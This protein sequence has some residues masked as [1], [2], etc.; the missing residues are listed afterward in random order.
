VSGYTGIYVVY[1][2]FSKYLEANITDASVSDTKMLQDFAEKCTRSGEL[3]MHI[4]LISHKEISNYI[5]K[6]PQQ[7]V[8]G[9]R[10][11]SER[12]KHIHLNNNF[13]QTYEIISTVIQKD[14]ALWDQF[15]DVHQKDFDNLY[16]R[17]E[18]H[19]I[20]LDATSEL[21][22]AI[23]GCFPLQPIS[24]FILPRLSER[25]AQNERTLFTFLSARGT[26]TLPEFLDGYNDEAFS[27]ITPDLLYDYFE[28]LFK[29]EAYAGDI[30]AKYILTNIILN[31]LDP[32]SLGSK[33]VKTI[34]L[35][36]I[37]EQFEKLKPTKEEIVGIYSASY[38]V[39]TIEAAI[40][41]LIKKEFV[42]YVKRSNDYLRLK[43]TSG[44]DVQQKIKDFVELY[45]DR[46][47]IKDTLNN[48][49]F[50]NYMY[51][52]RYNDD[53][54]MIRYFS[55]EFIEGLEITPEIDW[56]K[57]SEGS[58]SDGI[59]FGIIPSGDEGLSDLKKLVV[60]TSKNCPRYI[61]VLP[62]CYKEI[63]SVIR[64]YEAVKN[65]REKAINDPVLFD[66]YEVVFEDLQEIIKSFISKYT[67]P[68]T[69]ASFYIYD[70]KELEIRRKAAL[71]EL[72]SEICD[73]IYSLTPVINNESVNRREITS[74]AANSR[75]K[76]ISGLL[77]GELESN[78]G[79]TGSGQEVS[80]MRSTLIR[81]G[82]WKEE[83]GIP[84]I[85]L[86]PDNANMGNLLS[87]IE[88]FILEARQFGT[89]SFRV[90]YDRL[91][92]PDN[93]IGLRNGLIPIYIAVVMHEYRQ[94]I[95]VAGKSGQV[96]LNT[97]VLMQ[98]NA[99]P[100]DFSLEYL[101]WNP[102][103]ETYTKELSRVFED[104]VVNAEKAG[105]SYDYVAN[106]MRRWY[107]ALPK[108]SK[109]C[110]KLP[111]GGLI[112]KRKQE[113]IKLLRQNISGSELLF[114]KI[115]EIFGYDEFTVDVTEEVIN[116]KTL[117]DGLLYE[118]RE[119]LISV[120][121]DIFTTSSASKTA[122]R[123][124]LVSI[125]REWLE[126]LDESVGEQLFADGT[127]KF[128]ELISSVTNDE[129][130]FISRVA[131]LA[132]DLRLEDWD[133]KMPQLYIEAIK[134][135][136]A[137]AEAFRGQKAMET[138]DLT[139]GYQVTFV[140]EEGENVTK[141]FD[142]VDVSSRGKLLHN[143]ITAALDSMGHSITEQEKRQ[144]LMEV[145]RKLC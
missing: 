17:Y 74:V 64:E 81:T 66:E 112:I 23:K 29:K 26:S 65:L 27:L 93:H 143:Q 10:G 67:H 69:Y 14:Q 13:S 71:T 106:A 80:I 142:K 4:M 83:G 75:N 37:L 136:K 119:Y 38:E 105:N 58:L 36:Y 138:V 98:I 131:K 137:T 57:K 77:R 55:F 25:V 103:K 78:L 48:T 9:W 141:R 86:K 1:D 40:N 52:S 111:S 92:S 129:H 61:F 42:I 39:E 12:F 54:E 62:R 76:I 126:S 120:T 122:N 127:E 35:I 59:I 107:M 2:E 96:T 34:S 128:I 89:M 6:L 3:Q 94:Q 30:H 33:I 50:D 20:F 45:S 24:T 145:L 140:T 116:T 121:K 130:L 68:E 72:M 87:V 22:T 108:Y 99:S 135:F 15:C 125:I 46:V 60:E 85:N 91:T 32:E 82:I 117:Y 139:N 5:D 132:T 53:R 124:S 16:Q 123:M 8:D 102:E 88:N 73:D 18:K 97:D 133:D 49:N 56:N 41:D 7:K 110:K 43:Q 134:R 104:Y 115:P 31:Q 144:I 95:V 44:V 109:E 90:L 51:P 79:L 113:L 118:L 114:K 101:D 21:D 19:Q 84:S 100:E 63:S 70:G 11:V 28:P 47:T